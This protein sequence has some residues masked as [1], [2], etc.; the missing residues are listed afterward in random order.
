MWVISALI[1]AVWL[2]LKFALHRGGYVHI[3][4]LLGI[5]IFVVQLVTY[6]KTRYHATASGSDSS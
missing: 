4:L 1:L 3:L 2:V 6:R 5:S